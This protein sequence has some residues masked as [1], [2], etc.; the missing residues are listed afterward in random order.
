MGTRVRLADESDAEQ[1]L[2]IYRLYVIETWITFELEP[3]S[4]EE[5]RR[6]VRDIL[7][8]ARLSGARR[9]C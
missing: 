5:I 4:I 1:I 2:R 7:V 6:R 8:C 3:P 9:P